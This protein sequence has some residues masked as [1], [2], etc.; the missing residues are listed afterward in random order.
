MCGFKVFKAISNYLVQNNIIAF[1][2]DDRGIGKSTG[3][4]FQNTFKFS[5]IHVLYS[6]AKMQSTSEDLATDVISMVKYLKG[7][8]DFS[9]VEIGL[10]GHSEG[11]IIAYMVATKIPDGESLVF[12][13]LLTS[14][15]IRTLKLCESQITNDHTHLVLD[16]AFIISM[17]GPA[18]KGDQ[19]LLKQKETIIKVHGTSSQ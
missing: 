17:G 5:W 16:I 2:Y 13:L 1:R 14:E 10:L 8:N 12:F 3:T 19:L 6:G 7:R 18:V 4:S 9:G 15:S 11:G